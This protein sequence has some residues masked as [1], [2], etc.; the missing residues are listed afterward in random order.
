V[1]LG[2]MDNGPGIA[3][4][5]RDKVFQRFYR[6]LGS[7][8]EGSGLGL[9]IVREVAELHG[10]MVSLHDNPATTGLLVQVVFPLKSLPALEKDFTVA[11]FPSS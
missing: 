4:D 2:V 5:E 6:V 1:V 7:A 10:G 8:A 11:A 3:R 9:A